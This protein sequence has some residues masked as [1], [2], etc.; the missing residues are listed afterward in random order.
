MDYSSSPIPQISISL[1]PPE[2]PPIEPSSPFSSLAFNTIQDDDGF[3]AVHLTPP[4]TISSFKRVLSPRSPLNPDPAKQSKG[5]DNDRFQALLNATKERSAYSGGKKDVDLRKEIALKV[6]KNKQLERRA[7]FL[8]KVQAPPS[9]TATVTPKTPPESPAIFH[10]SLP[11]PGLV[12]PL[13]LFESLNEDRGAVPHTWIEQV[14][15]RLPEEQ[16]KQSKYEKVGPPRAL[17]SLDQISARLISRHG[18]AD[19]LGHHDA[20]PII[21]VSRPRPSVGVGRLRM[22]IRAQPAAPIE[23]KPQPVLP[24]K[25]PLQLD[26]ELRVTTLV[27][28]RTSTTY[29]AVELTETNLNALNSRGQT[30][31]NM[32]STLRRRT[33][34][35]ES[36]AAAPNPGDAEAQLKWRRRSAPPDMMQQSRARTGFEHPVLALPGGF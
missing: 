2:V 17:P 32:L 10:Y 34:S 19:P 30:A 23:Q 18:K 16:S 20:T 35:T 21:T 1:A 24:P 5:L 6:H 31:H 9:P 25:S 4:P 7:L 11:S 12:S 27:V 3:R 33:L 29:R 36:K 8:S 14:D 22:P 26:P 13:A 28:P 15:F